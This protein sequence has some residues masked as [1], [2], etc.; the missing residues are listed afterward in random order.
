MQKS[1]ADSAVFTASFVEKFK[2]C[3]QKL[4]G[5]DSYMDY[6]VVPSLLGGKTLSYLPLLNY[7]DRCFDEVEDLLELAKD[8]EYQIRT[9]HFDYDD[10]K[11][12]DTVTMRLEIEGRTSEEVFAAEVKPRC[13]NK[14]RN[15]SKRYGYSCT[16]GNE[17]KDRED[18]Y[19]IF[20]A[21]MHRHG[22]PV[23]DR[24]LFR[25]LV[26]TFGE[27]ILFCNAYKEG[28]VVASMC[29]LFDERI[30]W[31]PWGGVEREYAKELAGYYIYWE[32]LRYVC[33][34]RRKCVFDFGRSAYGGTTYMFKAQFGAK[35]VKIDI[36]TRK[37]EDIYEKYALASEI[38][39]RLPKG[40]T[41]WIG[42]KLCRYLVDL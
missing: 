24:K 23:L 36:L 34:E 12:E 33:D 21:T 15:A 20:S 18:F 37:R 17:A 19:T 5:Y 2:E 38:W 32:A 22:T 28:R 35:P 41:D 14:V 11:K 1:A 6:L 25:L 3:V 39:K 42:P 29:L 7:T 30:A 40:L 13:R 26:E 16:F 31:Y 8:N 27:D 9:L 10:F 4:Y